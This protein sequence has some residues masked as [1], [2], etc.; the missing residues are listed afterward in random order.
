MSSAPLFISLSCLV[1]QIKADKGRATASACQ[2]RPFLPPVQWLQRG[3]LWTAILWAE[4]L[5]EA[6]APPRPTALPG[7]K[8]IPW[9][10]PEPRKIFQAPGAGRAR[11]ACGC[12]SSMDGPSLHGSPP[13]PGPVDSSDGLPSSP[14]PGRFSLPVRS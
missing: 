8:G 13:S 5:Q 1:A 2:E 7:P 3:R 14:Q 12:L 10:L 4:Q 6:P 11:E 9:P